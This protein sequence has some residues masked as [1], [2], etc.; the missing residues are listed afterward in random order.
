M[1]TNND[2]D[3]KPLQTS[4]QISFS[5]SRVSELFRAEAE[6]RGLPITSSEDVITLK[7]LYGDIQVFRERE[8]VRLTL[9]ASN[10]TRLHLLREAVDEGLDETRSD[11]SRTWSLSEPGTYPHNL[12]FATV[13][14][15]KRLSPSFFRVT[16]SDPS[17]ERFSCD[18]LHF[19]L[20]FPLSGPCRKMADHRRQRAHGMAR[21]HGCVAQACLH[22]TRSRCGG[23]TYGLRRFRS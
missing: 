12:A 23:W 6:T 4:T 19:R 2:S 22:D 18:G 20:L 17:L 8:G 9:S 15:C 1:L 13:Q 5:F 21:R 7:A 10:Q 14:S 16:L 11:L 3:Q